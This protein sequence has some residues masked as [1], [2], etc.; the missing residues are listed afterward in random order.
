MSEKQMYSVVVREKQ[1]N[2]WMQYTDKDEI[3]TCE[4][5][6]IMV[7]QIEKNHPQIEA[8]KVPFETKN[9]ESHREKQ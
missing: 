8:M 5:A 2:Y 4:I 3:L 6:D 1:T 7:Q 9:F